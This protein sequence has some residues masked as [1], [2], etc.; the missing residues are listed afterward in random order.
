MEHT[1]EESA[2]ESVEEGSNKNNNKHRM[3][4]I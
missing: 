2:G 4:K 3:K 1:D